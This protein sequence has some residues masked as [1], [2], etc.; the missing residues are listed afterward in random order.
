[1]TRYVLNECLAWERLWHEVSTGR[2]GLSN[3]VGLRWVV[4]R[5]RNLRRRHAGLFIHRPIFNDCGSGI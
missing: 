5:Q 3:S 1:M 2:S 4:A